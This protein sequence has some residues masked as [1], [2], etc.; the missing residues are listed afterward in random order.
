MEGFYPPG[1]NAD[2][3]LPFDRG[4]WI[5]FL[6]GIYRSRISVYTSMRFIMIYLFHPIP[7]VFIF[8]N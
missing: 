6:E 8:I 5:R 7:V 3:S 4:I 1:I 2:V